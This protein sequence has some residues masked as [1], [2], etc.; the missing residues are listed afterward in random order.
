MG[1]YKRYLTQYKMGPIRVGFLEEEKPELTLKGRPE[2]P[3][4][5]VSKVWPLD[6]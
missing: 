4:A 5:V 1:T 2:L 6:H 3:K